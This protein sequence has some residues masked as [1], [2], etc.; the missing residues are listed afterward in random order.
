MTIVVVGISLVNSLKTF[1][2]IWI[3]TQGGPYRSS[4]TLAVTMYRETFLLFRHGYGSAI[5]V[6]LSVIVMGVSVF[7][8]SKSLRTS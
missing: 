7:Y 3:M 6:V 1:D 2:I 5:A 4:E 8:L